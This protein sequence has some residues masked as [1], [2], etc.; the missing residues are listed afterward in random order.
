MSL[1]YQCD[2]RWWKDNNVA[3]SHSGGWQTPIDSGQSTGERQRDGV[4]GRW[5]KVDRERRE[6]KE[7]VI[8]SKQRGRNSGLEQTNRDFQMKVGREQWRKRISI[9]K[10]CVCVCLCVCMQTCTHGWVIAGLMLIATSQ[11][12]E[13]AQQ[14]LTRSCTSACTFFSFLKRESCFNV[15]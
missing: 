3:S 15:I 5:K 12:G 6:G 10:D 13:I 7:W 14:F 2:V 9:W 4:R 11:Y 8:V 1:K